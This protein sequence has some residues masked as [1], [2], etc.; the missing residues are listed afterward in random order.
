MKK[1]IGI[2]L[3]TTN[4]VVAFKTKSVEILRNKENQE[5]TRSCVGQRNSEILVGRAAFQLLKRDP[6]NTILS[7]KRLMG[8]GYHDE[9][10]QKMIA[11]TRKVRG[12]YK[13]AITQLQGGTDNAVAVLLQGKQYTPEQISAEIL[14]KL[15][16][17]AEDKL[18]DEVTHAVITVPAYFT[19]KQK[20]ATKLAAKYAGLKVQKLLAEPTA[21]AIAYGLLSVI[22][23][24]L[25]KL[26]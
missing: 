21:A 13:Y 8:V 16:G 25:N 20:N 26:K 17:D 3:G 22:S 12:Y 9:M 1:V 14:K 6:E 5:L 15:K 24:K 10:T 18:N 2:D 7:V 19:D 23:S 4:S 11:E